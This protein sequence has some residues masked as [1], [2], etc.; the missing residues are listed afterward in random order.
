MCTAKFNTHI[1]PFYPHSV[2]MCP[3]CLL[4]ETIIY[5]PIGP[6][7]SPFRL[8]NGSTLL[9]VRYALILTGGMS[10]K[11]GL[12]CRTKTEFCTQAWPSHSLY[13]KASPL[14]MVISRLIS[15]L[16]AVPWLRPLVSG[17]KPRSS[18]V[19]PGPFYVIFVV[20]K[21]TP[22]QGLACCD[23]PHSVSF[24]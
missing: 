23:C 14:Y 17:L 8:S 21:V 22:G 7:H 13:R 10:C 18:W 2:F 15:I 11:Q 20:D 9:S 24:H 16:K 6:Y 1:S 12:G 5:L 4:H 3:A 19:D